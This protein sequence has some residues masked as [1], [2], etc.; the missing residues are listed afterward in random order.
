MNF[1]RKLEPKE[2]TQKRRT[3]KWWG[4]EMV[5][6]L[7][8]RY[9]SSRPFMKS[10]KRCSCCTFHLFVIRPLNRCRRQRADATT[11]ALRRRPSWCSYAIE[12][13]PVTEHEGGLNECFPSITRF[14]SLIDPCYRWTYTTNRTSLHS[15]P[16]LWTKCCHLVTWHLKEKKWNVHGV[17]LA[18]HH[19][20]C[21]V[22]TAG[23]S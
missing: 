17:L 14:Y 10:M 12:N 1:R 4:A 5:L 21:A 22:N 19:Q 3:N 7:L 16:L 9:C 6:V 11:P 8:L 23:V 18:C 2:R 13:K 20:I 15:L